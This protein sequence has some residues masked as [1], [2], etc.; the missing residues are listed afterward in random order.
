MLERRRAR[1]ATAGAYAASGIWLGAPAGDNLAPGMAPR[2]LWNVRINSLSW[3]PVTESNRR[4]SPY[5]GDALPTELTGRVFNCLTWAFAIRPRNAQATRAVH[6][7]RALPCRASTPELAR[8]ASGTEHSVPR[9]YASLAMCILHYVVRTPPAC[10]GPCS[11][12]RTSPCPIGPSAGER[13]VLG[14]MRGGTVRHSDR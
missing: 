13:A 9:R 11:V 10:H 1:T 8:R 14:A 5:H 2:E 4:P 7:A 12:R 6:S 3:S